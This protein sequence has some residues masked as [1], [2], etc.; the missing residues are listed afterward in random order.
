MQWW[1]TFSGFCVSEANQTKSLFSFLLCPFKHKTI[2]C[3]L[4][5][6]EQK[7]ACLAF[8]RLQKE[9]VVE[10]IRLKN[11][12]ALKKK[13]KNLIAKVL[14][15]HTQVLQRKICYYCFV[16]CYISAPMNPVPSESCCPVT[17]FSHYILSQTGWETS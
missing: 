17:I 10:Q 3:I 11:P 16:F 13:I 14:V 15:C 2:Y 7:S 12:S 9:I 4:S 1:K 6:E 8:V 5:S